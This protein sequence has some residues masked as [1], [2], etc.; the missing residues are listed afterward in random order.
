MAG[1]TS[2]RFYRED[3]FVRN[4]GP[5]QNSGRRNA[6]PARQLAGSADPCDRDFK[7]GEVRFHA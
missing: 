1:D 2:L 3:T 7:R 6:E 4:F 5:L